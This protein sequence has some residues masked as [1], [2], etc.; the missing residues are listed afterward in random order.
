MNIWKGLNRLRIRVLSISR[1]WYFKSRSFGLWRRV[2]LWY[3]INVSEVHADTLVCYNNTTRRHS[4]EDCIYRQQGPLKRYPT[5]TLHSITIHKTSTWLS[6]K[7]TEKRFDENDNE[8]S[9]STKSRYF[10]TSLLIINCWRQ[11]MYSGIWPDSLH[12]IVPRL[13]MFSLEPQ[14]AHYYSNNIWNCL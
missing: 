13:H 3:V 8:P 1:R 9:Y 6:I 11:I 14:I 10:L 4:P 12:W 5:T 7:P 2:V